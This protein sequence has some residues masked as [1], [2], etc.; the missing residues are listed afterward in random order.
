[1]LS[2]PIRRKSLILAG[3]LL[4]VVRPA[5]S[6]ESTI[7]GRVT[8]EQGRPLA[9]ATVAVLG[10]TLSAGTTDSGRYAIRLDAG[11]LTNQGIRLQARAIG[12]H[13]VAVSFS[14][15]P[16]P[17][18]QDFQLVQDP[19]RLDEIVV[20]GVLRET[21]QR[22]LALSVSTVSEAQLQE[23]PSQDPFT[24]LI[25]KVP[26]AI[27]SS[28]A[29]GA[30]GSPG[31]IR[32]RSA[33]SITPGAQSQQPLIIIDGL[34][35]REGIADLNVLDIERIEVVK[36]P[37]G[38]SLYGSDAAAGV[39]QIF[40]RRGRY[41][42]EGKTL[43]SLRTEF[44]RS[45]PIVFLKRNESHFCQNYDPAG[46]FERNPDGTVNCEIDPDH[47]YLDQP[48]PALAPW[49]N[50]QKN[51][52]GSQNIITTNLAI[53]RRQGGT[54]LY[55][56]W[57][58]T[59]NDGVIDVPGL[60]LKG[61]VRHNLRLNLDQV[62]SPAFDLSLSGFYANSTNRIPDTGFG[63][64]EELQF[65]PPDVDLLA[66]NANGQPYQIDA[67]AY[68]AIPNAFLG[69]PLYSVSVRDVTSGRSRFQG[70]AR[71]RWRPSSWLS[72]EGAYAYDRLSEDY[73]EVIPRGTLLPS[74]PESPGTITVV[75]MDYRSYNAS[76][77]A[78]ATRQM[79]DV[80]GTLTVTGLLE[81]THRGTV[82][83]TGSNFT[84]SGAPS[85]GNT[86]PTTQHTQEREETIRARSY[87]A[88][89]QLDYKD[90]YVL[91]ALVRSD[92]TS[93]FGE[94]ARWRTFYRASGAWRVNKNFPIRGV[95]E[96]RLRASI[97][98][99]GLRPPFEAQYETYT[100]TS[101]LIKPGVLGNR[102]LR[103]AYSTEWDLGINL[104][105]LSRFSL[106]YTYARKTTRDQVLPVPVTAITGFPAQWQNAGTLEGYSHELSFQ[107]LLKQATDWSWRFGAT[108]DRSRATITELA[109]PAYTDPVQ[110]QRY[111]VGVAYGSYDITRFV[112]SCEELRRNPANA[113]KDCAN[114]EVNSDGYLIVKGTQ[115]TTDERPILFVDENGR[116]SFPVDPAPDFILGLQTTVTWKGGTLY[117]LLDWR[118]G[119]RILD[120]L[121]T[122]D[123]FSGTYTGAYF[124]QRGKP[125]G[126]KKTPDYYEAF[127]V[128]GGAASA[129]GGSANDWNLLDG[130]YARLREVSLSWTF[131][132]RDLARIGANRWI[133]GA[134][135]ALIGRNL[136]TITK[137]DG[138]DP[139][140]NLSGA[141][142]AYGLAPNRGIP[143]AGD[144][145]AARMV[146]SYPSFRTISA[147]LELSF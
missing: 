28:S 8:D 71:A 6:Q 103:P 35:T 120:N 25:G 32:L 41:I 107:A 13:P 57:D 106:E 91:D 49:R 18:V 118:Q 128:V 142:A 19:F 69:N 3:I 111:E 10:T 15:T 42:P 11:R 62:V 135:V 139:E 94:D 141:F 109:V 104:D 39:V 86:D 16:G 1:M 110:F 70:N 88:G 80:G 133:S 79:G 22:R 126:L 96:L 38:A 68:S 53:A 14:L 95:D 147:V 63:A 124:D 51:F 60:D 116:R 102:D 138:W 87:A 82:T 81:D 20:S 52:M 123:L 136:F 89:L 56:S 121:R 129:M 33:T 114:Y 46:D 84:S 105:L 101:G 143:P 5:W 117:G 17:H 2:P 100:V 140:S 36:G 127:G 31:F 66:P 59:G 9:G 74:Q 134:R 131:T 37:A 76:G 45:S 137:V 98:S 78:R 73:R 85:L 50:Q 47:P 23:V 27:V 130:S 26:G 112:R 7:S 67:A 61:L 119:G 44:G 92:G 108:V 132:R 21:E 65:T 97:G 24:A 58:R 144:P 77:T 113:T 93:L 29:G 64:W 75:N 43:I 145:T 54:N 48:Y 90:R 99:A 40:T 115:G 125:E 72:A 30:P 146:A 12:R 83:S 122:R 55:G 34:L 4:V